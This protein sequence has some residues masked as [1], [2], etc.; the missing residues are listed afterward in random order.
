MREQL[1]YEPEVTV[2]TGDFVFFLLD[3]KVDGKTSSLVVPGKITSVGDGEYEAHVY[4]ASKQHK[5][6]MPAWECTGKKDIN[7]RTKP[8]GYSPEMARFTQK[9]IELATQL[10]KSW[11]IPKQAWAAMKAK[12]V[13]IL[14]EYTEKATAVQTATVVNKTVMAM[15][16]AKA[17]R[18][19]NRKDRMPMKT[20]D[21]QHVWVKLMLEQRGL[22]IRDDAH[23]D[24]GRLLH[25]MV[26]DTTSAPSG[27]M[28]DENYANILASEGGPDT[29]NMV[30]QMQ[31]VV[32][33]QN[34]TPQHTCSGSNSTAVG[35]R[36]RGNRPATT[37]REYADRLRSPGG[38]ST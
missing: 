10:T 26:Y 38:T 25:S 34:R 20:G 6:Y 33:M 17:K 13:V 23:L 2:K 15:T 21:P 31:A 5:C 36:R 28:M 16:V 14:L 7:Q 8:K 27:A 12:G 24:H 4:D 11:K 22:P 37:L 32:T 35:R 19:P 30:P 3:K 29:G 9:D 18:R 1:R